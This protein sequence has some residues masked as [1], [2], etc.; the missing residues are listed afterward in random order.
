[1]SCSIGQ[2]PESACQS[3]TDHT[4]QPIIVFIFLQVGA[5]LS[6]PG[7]PASILLNIVHFHFR[8][9]IEAVLFKLI[10]SPN[11]RG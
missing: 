8:V 10:N 7:A 2:M 3:T 9:L 4:S 1:M 6:R 11:P 5:G